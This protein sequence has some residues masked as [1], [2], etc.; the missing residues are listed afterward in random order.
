MKKN[1]KSID[2]M[3]TKCYNRLIK[4]KENKNMMNFTELEMMGA[5]IEDLLE[6]AGVDLDELE[7]V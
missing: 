4:R 1:K 2:R 6:L 5:T 7:E 3:K